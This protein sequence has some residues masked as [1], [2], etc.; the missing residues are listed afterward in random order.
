[1]ILDLDQTIVDSSCSESFRKKR[2]WEK[3]YELI[4]QFIVYEGMHEVIRTLRKRQIQIAIVTSSPKTYSE[5]VLRYWN[6]DYDHLISYHDT[7]RHKP[8][9]EP[10][11]LALSTMGLANEEV[12]SIG[13]QWS[14]IV[15][16]QKAAVWTISC[17]W[18]N[19]DNSELIKQNPHLVVSEP[20]QLISRINKEVS[21]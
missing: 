14:D 20:S 8:D 9:P 10:I 15:A 13:D 1:M 3:V 4:P 16:S 21:C 18:G 19:A 6:I 17:L 7:K 12:A 2:E 11:N 5:K